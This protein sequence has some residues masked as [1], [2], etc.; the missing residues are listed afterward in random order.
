VNEF[1][2]Y[3]VCECGAHRYAPHGSLFHA[4]TGGVVC[5]ACGRHIER[6]SHIEVARWISD[7]VW[8]R[9]A[10]W[11]RGHYEAADAAGGGRENG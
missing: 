9:P 2:T 3:A 5:P 4:T 1:L 10:T 7:Q 6:H 8:Y 11:G